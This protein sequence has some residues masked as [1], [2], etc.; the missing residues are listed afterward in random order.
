MKKQKEQNFIRKYLQTNLRMLIVIHQKQYIMYQTLT[1]FFFLLGQLQSA[2]FYLYPCYNASFKIYNK[3]IL[4]YF[5]RPDLIWI[6]NQMIGIDNKLLFLIPLICWLFF[7]ILVLQGQVIYQIISR[8]QNDNQSNQIEISGSFQNMVINI[9]SIYSQLFIIYFYIPAQVLSFTSFGVS[10]GIMNIDISIFSIITVIITLINQMIKLYVSNTCL[11]LTI[12][13]YERLYFTKFDFFRELIILIQLI[14]F[15]ILNNCDKA[16][17]VQGIL[18]LFVNLT[19]IFNVIIDKSIVIERFAQIILII[20]IS[21]IAIIATSLLNYWQLGLILIPLCIS[22]S[23]T[24]RQQVI[25][26]LYQGIRLEKNVQKIIHYISYQ[27]NNKQRN[28]EGIDQVSQAILLYHHRQK[29]NDQICHCNTIRNSTDNPSNVLFLSQKLHKQFIIQKIKHWNKE[30]NQKK[31]FSS[32]N[33]FVYYISALNHFGFTTLAFQECN[34]L[35]SLSTNQNRGFL[36]HSDAN[37]LSQSHQQS[38]P[39]QSSESQNKVNQAKLQEMNAKS[40]EKQQKIKLNIRNN[41]LDQLSLIKLKIISKDIKLE[42][43]NN[44][45]KQQTKQQEEIADAIELYLQS[46]QQNQMVK[47]KILKCLQQKLQFYNMI[48][49]KKGL[50]SQQL[51][52][53]AKIISNLFYELEKELLFQYSQFPSQKIQSINCFFQSEILNNYLSAFKLSNFSTIA[54]DKLINMKKNLKI[55][56]FGKN[57]VHMILYLSDNLSTLVISQFSNNTHQ[58]LQ[59]SYEDFIKQNKIID[60]ILPIAIKNEHYML[61]QRFMNDGK[62]KY[63]RNIDISFLELQNGFLKPFNLILDIVLN[64]TEHLSF[65]AFFEE[66]SLGNSYILVDV[67]GICGGI[68]A[69]LLERSGWK[70]SEIKL[71]PKLINTSYQININS[72]IPDFNELKLQIKDNKFYNVQIN[73]LNKKLLIGQES[74]TILSFH[75]FWKDPGNLSVYKG[76][77][78][79]SSRELYGYYYY[80]IEIED[81]RQNQTLSHM[82]HSDGKGMITQIND[83]DN[84]NEIEVSDLEVSQTEAEINKPQSL[85]IFQQSL[86]EIQQDIENNSFQNHKMHVGLVQHLVNNKQSF[87]DNLI[88]L[89]QSFNNEQSFDNHKNIEHNSNAIDITPNQS[90]RKLIDTSKSFGQQ[91]FFNQEIQ[92]LDQS[93]SK[94]SEGF[95][96]QMKDVNQLYD[97]D[98]NKID[99][100]MRENIKM[101]LQLEIDQKNQPNQQVDDAASQVSSLIG[102]KKSLFYKKYELIN[103]IIDSNFK[104]ISYKLC[105]IFFFIQLILI[106]IYSIIIL[107]NLNTDFNRFI[108]EVDMLLFSYSFMTPFDIFLSLRFSTIYYQIQVPSRMTAVEFA[109]LSSWLSNH[110]GEG[111]D[112]MK[113]NFLEQFSN[114]QLLDFFTDQEF[115]VQFMKQ[116]STQMEA[117]TLSFRESLNVLLSYQ[118]QFKI[119]YLKK[120]SL[121]NQPFSAYPYFN[122]L[123]LHDKFDNMTNEILDYTKERKHIVQD[124]WLS[125]WIPFLVLDFLFMSAT[126]YYYTQYLSIYESFLNLFKFTDEIWLNRDIE[127]YKI[128]I[129]ILTKNSDVIFKYQFDLEQK[130]KFMMAEKYKKESKIIHDLKK[131][132]NYSNY[133]KLPRIYGLIGISFVF[134]V[135]F[136]PALLIQLQTNTYLS[137]YV[138]T[139]DFYKFTG[140]LCFQLPGMFSQR[141]FLYWWSIYNLD[142]NDKPR[143]IARLFNS[144]DNLKQFDEYVQNFNQEDY[145]TT[146]IFIDKLNQLTQNPVCKFFTGDQYNDYTFYCS[147]SFDGSLDMGLSQAL[148]YVANQYKVTFA[149]NNFTSI[150]QYFK[151]EAEG[152]YIMVKG[153]IELVSSL[154]EALLQATISQ[155]DQIIGLSVFLLV[156]QFII[157][158]LQ[159]FILHKYYTEEYNLVKRYM[160]LLP[161]STLLLDDNFERNIRI[162]Y[163]Q[164]QI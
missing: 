14:L 47:H 41:F 10:E 45:L 140:D 105:H 108:Q 82:S 8:K 46:E 142:V 73:L 87:A 64:Q 156:F 120:T 69:N 28:L 12:K 9:K 29:C 134:S 74:R 22:I 95:Q 57:V 106:A 143:M 99:K 92:E 3:F 88:K 76:T 44:F 115:E 11:D 4:I 123:N 80:I 157:F 138:N 153:M 33:S 1:Y 137:K 60:S 62:C 164:Y 53:N 31:D 163:A 78:I 102:L 112:D 35:L 110:L 146:Q 51:F 75:D 56:L 103:G 52:D 96:N 89:N 158:S 129:N 55:N 18:I 19:Y 54:D 38:F 68:T 139:A 26:N 61:V 32:N 34:R 113:L 42:L 81:L 43:Q 66:V 130:E 154:K 63:F 15:G 91:R 119:A 133:D 59:Q 72:I 104:P 145:L 65:A 49:N 124:N 13:G 97:V 162:F 30:L 2:F 107:Q 79:I 48:L 40:I 58:F 24:Y 114:P 39:S 149:L 128:L 118:Y 16:Q 93:N 98:L 127:R 141:Q 36:S 136:I 70:A 23:F 25:M 111:Y 159:Y 122:Y 116:N 90:I 144:I 152:M 151:Y 131:K 85:N 37:S 121:T 94:I 109:E 6:D 83:Q 148:M 67:N 86:S 50:R 17:I 147:R 5:I 155:M 126:Y 135:F 160:L 150:V 84:T 71:N 117:K 132:K 100:E 125:I 27:I 7:D 77:I 21:L 101:Q 20:H 161:S